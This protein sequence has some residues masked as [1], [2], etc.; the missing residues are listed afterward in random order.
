MPVICFCGAMV[1]VA[2][3]G[4]GQLYAEGVGLESAN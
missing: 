3:V 4:M 1:G 2:A